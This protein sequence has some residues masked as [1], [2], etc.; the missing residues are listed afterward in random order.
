MKLFIS[1]HPDDE[2]LFGAYTIIKEKP[3]VAVFN[4]MGRQDRSN[5]SKEA[6]KLLGAES[7]F[8]DS[9]TEMGY[10]Y[11]V[12]YAPALQGGHPWH[13]EVCKMAI[14]RYSNKVV[15]YA[16]YDKLNIQP[17]GRF[18]VSA[19]DEMKDLKRKALL[20]YKS[21]IAETPVHFLIENK[22]EYLF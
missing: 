16:T 22:D 1:P 5:E 3:L 2:C 7:V 18:L 13:D 11:D 20:C 12:V 21:Q 6:I 9:I 14:K 15:Y 8:I 4:F 17:Y 19:S 10:Y